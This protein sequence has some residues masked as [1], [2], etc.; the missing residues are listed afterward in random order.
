MKAVFLSLFGA[1][2]FPPAALLPFLLMLLMIF[3]L[4]SWSN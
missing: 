2:D 3:P 4:Q 1:I